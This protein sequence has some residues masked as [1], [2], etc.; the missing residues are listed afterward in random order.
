MRQFAKVYPF[1]PLLSFTSCSQHVGQHL[2][3]FSGR[4]LGHYARSREKLGV[5]V[6]KT[7]SIYQQN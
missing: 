4:A 7:G 6:N 3:L 2:V 1:Y 5:L